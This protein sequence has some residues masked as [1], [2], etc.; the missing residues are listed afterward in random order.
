MIEQGNSASGAFFGGIYGEPGTGKTSAIAAFIY[1]MYERTGKPAL[2]CDEE[3]GS[4][5]FPDALEKGV[6]YVKWT[7]T[8]L[9]GKKLVASD[10][11][12]DVYEIPQL[13]MSGKYGC[14]VHDTI[15]SLAGRVMKSIVAKN[16]TG[17]A[18]GTARVHVATQAGKTISHPTLQDYGVAATVL[19]NYLNFLL[20]V[21]E[22]GMPILWVGHSKLITADDEDGNTI[23][24]VGTIE[25]VGKQMSRN[26]PK[27]MAFLIQLRKK[28]AGSEFK[29][30][31]DCVGDGTWT[32]KD[33]LGVWTRTNVA[34][35]KEEGMNEQQFQE[36]VVE[37]YL[38]LWE[39]WIEKYEKRFGQLWPIKKGAK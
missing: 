10:A 35:T 22:A 23:D 30:W 19:E 32:A 8:K 17:S 9:E 24:A 34:I 21:K 28:K 38:P 14:L 7:P 20:P 36:A 29:R 27:L 18:R 3:D 39:V 15:T 31:W 33:R 12:D 26:A 25:T 6:H 11:A 4:L 1:Y 2:Y 37:A 5:A 13:M 16:L